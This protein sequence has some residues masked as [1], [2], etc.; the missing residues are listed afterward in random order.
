MYQM[1]SHAPELNPAGDW[2]LMRRDMANLA[3]SDLPSLV[4]TVKHKMKKIKYGQGMNEDCIAKACLA[5]EA[6]VIT[7]TLRVE[8]GE[9]NKQVLCDLGF[10]DVGCRLN[11]AWVV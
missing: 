8:P 11:P 10:G 1:S 9:V 3:A 7:R 6:R 2:S 5:T 4:H